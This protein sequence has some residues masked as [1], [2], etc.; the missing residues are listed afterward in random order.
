MEVSGSAS[1]EFS[2]ELKNVFDKSKDKY[3][4]ILKKEKTA[5]KR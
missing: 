3:P 2:K 1:R 4:G 5:K